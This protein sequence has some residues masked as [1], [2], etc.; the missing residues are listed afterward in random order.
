MIET[1]FNIV[2]EIEEIFIKPHQ[3]SNIYFQQ[4]E[5]NTSKWD[6]KDCSFCGQS[7]SMVPKPKTWRC[8]K[9]GKMRKY[10]K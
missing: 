10:D 5:P 3:G 8:M 2:D 1:K 6:N 7:F 9:C 4:E